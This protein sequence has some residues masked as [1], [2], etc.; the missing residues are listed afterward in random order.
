M[1]RQFRKKQNDIWNPTGHKQIDEPWP[2]PQ[3]TNSEKGRESLGHHHQS[4]ESRY[5]G[6]SMS[7][8]IDVGSHL[9]GT[10]DIWSYYLGYMFLLGDL[11]NC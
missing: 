11:G 10:G 1:T 7:G 8:K 4:Y 6:A 3:R 5:A 9:V 2:E